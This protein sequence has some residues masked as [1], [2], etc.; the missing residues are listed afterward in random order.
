MKTKS[1]TARCLQTQYLEYSHSLIVILRHKLYYLRQFDVPLCTYTNKQNC[2]PCIYCS[3]VVKFV[4]IG[5]YNID[6]IYYWYN[7]FEFRN[8][9]EPYLYTVK[10][11]LFSQKQ[12]LRLT[13][14]SLKKKKK[15]TIISNA[16]LHLFFILWYHSF[17][18]FRR[19]IVFC[20]LFV[21]SNIVYI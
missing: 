20:R 10:N 15:W 13:L 5:S 11:R 12:W 14:K 9:V 6:H 2:T 21:V 1:L 18:C 17:M 19:K 8:I 3:L 4:I 7:I 16:F